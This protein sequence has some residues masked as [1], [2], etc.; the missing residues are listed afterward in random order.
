MGTAILLAAAVLSAIAVSHLRGSSSESRSPA[1][2]WLA[3]VFSL[4]V[5]IALLVV[6]KAKLVPIT[7][8]NFSVIVLGMIYFGVVEC[9]RIHRRLAALR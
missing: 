9:L 2:L 8:M 5:A 7:P 4:S 6:L 1:I 3:L